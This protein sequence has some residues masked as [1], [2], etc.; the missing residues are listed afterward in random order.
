LTKVERNPSKTKNKFLA[1]PPCFDGFVQSIEGVLLLLQDSNNYLLTSR[2]N[3]DALE[4]LFSAIRQRGGFN[5][6]P[7]V[8]TF[9][10]SFRLFTIKHLLEPAESSSYSPDDD[11]L[12][13]I[14]NDSPAIT[15]AEQLDQAST[16]AASLMSSESNYS[17]ELTEVRTCYQSIPNK[18]VTLE[19]C[20]Q[21]Y[22]ARKCLLLYNLKKA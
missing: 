3:Q 9:R 11:S 8:K 17:Q 12:L 10:S 4:N 19:D 20:S 15:P 13:N 14:N 5:R 22:F 18:S 16:S 2:V 7:T 21:V 6:N 1:R